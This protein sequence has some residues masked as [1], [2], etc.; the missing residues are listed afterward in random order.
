MNNFRNLLILFILDVLLFIQFIIRI[1][2]L[3][4]PS[5]ICFFTY[6]F[7]ALIYIRFIILLPSEYSKHVRKFFI[8]NA[9]VLIFIYAVLRR[10]A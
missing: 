10:L 2:W 1:E 3:L 8:I 7:T 5:L 4:W 9:I 6:L